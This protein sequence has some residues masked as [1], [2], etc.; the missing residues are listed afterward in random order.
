MSE[1]LNA[2]RFIASQV[3]TPAPAVTL[4]HLPDMIT[5]AIALGKE[6]SADPRT[7]LT[8]ADEVEHQR[9]SVTAV[10][11]QSAPVIAAAREDLQ[12]LALSLIRR[13]PELLLLS[14]SPNP[15]AALNARMQLVAL[16]EMSMQAA[17]SRVREMT[18]ALLPLQ[19]QLTSIVALAPGALG[20]AVEGHGAN[21]E[22]TTLA[23]PDSPE[24][25][26]FAQASHAPPAAATDGGAVGERAVAAARSA[27][28]TPYVWG[29]TTMNGFDCS[30]LTQWAW[31]QAGV[32]IP[33]TADQ[34]AVGRAVSFTE[35]QAGD[36]L[37]WDGHAAMYAGDGQ[38]IEAGNPV[39]TN[40]I[41]TSN[42]GMS[43]HGFYR[44]TG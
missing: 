28:G 34:Q 29:G 43:F 13:I 39:Q 33:R 23:A 37:I 40:P 21:N 35:L 10:L 19:D 24:D 32:D 41:R 36:L 7:L 38:I 5:P 17:V 4:P 15:G 16:A 44:P 11:A 22:I 30:G 9:Q 31:A 3:P 6:I 20:A 18:S 8:L 2:V 1:L 42:M 14:L 27:L 26:H 25:M 12:E